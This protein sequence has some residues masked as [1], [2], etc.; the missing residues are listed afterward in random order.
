MLVICLLIGVSGSVSAETVSQKE[1]KRIASTFFNAA[2]GQ[3]MADPTLVYNGRKLT[4]GSYFA[5]FYVYNLPVRGFV[6][7]SAENKAFP[8][9]GYS[10]TDNFSPDKMGE[11][12]KGLL[13]LYASHI[14]NIRYDSSVPYEAMEAWQDIPGYISALLDAPYSATDPETS[15]DEAMA[16]LVY[17]ASG[18]D[19]TASASV[20]YTPDQ[21]IDLIDNE[22]HLKKDVPV[23]IVSGEDMAA[24][25][26]YGRKGDMFRIRLDERDK[27]LWRLLPTEIIS[28]GQIAVLGNP[29]VVPSISDE[30]EPFS[31][32]DD[33]IAT[34]EAEEKARRA[35]IE[36]TVIREDPVVL[37]HGS[38][39]FSVTL[40]EEV[41][42]MRVYS[43]DGQLVQRD[44]FRETNTANVEL[45]Q[46]PTGFYFAVF[47]GES[48]KPY[49]VKLF[50]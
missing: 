8:I 2:H 50:R 28:V 26:V 1:A 30:E 49:P 16:E 7:V 32:Y 31:F 9:L 37:W 24:A 41:V 15:Q 39:H 42:S 17:V 47:F 33:F 20:T 19:A 12:L 40:P 27:S 25:V 13:T 29:P 11:S 21:W 23:G 18:D 22:L 6:V 48:G 43:L 38:G 36:Q 14:E 35:A 44:A 46:N 10:L 4:T 5:P 45:T 3:K 34:V